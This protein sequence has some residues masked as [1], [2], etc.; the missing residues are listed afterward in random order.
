MAFDSEKWALS[1]YG[2]IDERFAVETDL[3]NLHI[4]RK[5]GIMKLQAERSV[6][7]LDIFIPNDWD[8][9]EY[10][11]QKKMRKLMLTEIEWQALN[12]YQQRTNQI[13][14]RIGLSDVKVSVVNRGKA[15]L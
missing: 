6:G 9:E 4:Y 1:F 15:S 14:S 8:M 11:N 7:K 5:Q 3:F 2:V 12:I 10:G 13:A